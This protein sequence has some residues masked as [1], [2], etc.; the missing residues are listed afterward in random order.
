MMKKIITLAAISTGMLLSA[1]ANA[2]AIPFSGGTTEIT[3]LNC[4]ALDNNVSIQLSKGVT[5]AFN[6]DATSFAAAACH[7]NGTNKQ[8]TLECLYYQVVNS[9]P[10]EHL[11]MPGYET[12][13]AYDANAATPPTITFNGRLAFGAKSGG[14]RVTAIPL[15][16]ATSCD[17]TTILPA[18][19]DVLLDSQ[20]SK[21]TAL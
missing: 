13:P 14:G 12:C 16:N 8:Q 3:P 10:V 21:A 17:T 15:G 18:A 19:P 2:A 7:S 5:A 1:Q 4:P 11:P 9:N 6:C 20:T